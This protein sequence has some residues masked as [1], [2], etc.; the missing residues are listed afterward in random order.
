MRINLQKLAA[1][2]STAA[3]VAFVACSSDSGG[4]AAG[5]CSYICGCACKGQTT[6]ECSN[7]CTTD[8]SKTSASCQK[9]VAAV[10]CED[11]VGIMAPPASCQA[12]CSGGTGG[13]GGGGVGGGGGS[14]GGTGGGGG[15]DAVAKC[16]ALVDKLCTWG[17]KCG[18]GPK[19]SCIA[20]AGQQLNCSAAKT[21]GAS[22][23]QCVSELDSLPCTATGLPTA[24]NGVIGI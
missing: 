7:A 22:Y 23:D 24:C 1:M 11:L 5:G 16:N 8:C 9:C 6:Q 18:Q 3:L 10:K 14:G 21:V 4:G 2:M 12:D 15:G 20:S 13:T 17:E 19:A